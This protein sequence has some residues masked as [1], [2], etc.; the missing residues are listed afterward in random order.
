MKIQINK[1]ILNLLK[2]NNVYLRPYFNYGDAENKLVNVVS[3]VYAEEFS[4]IHENSLAWGGEGVSIGAFSYLVPGAIVPYTSIGRYCSIATGVRVMSPGHPIDRVTTSTWTYGGNINNIV[5][6]AYGV[7]I[8][9]NR[10]LKKNEKT[11]I[12]NDVWIGEFAVV[13]SGVTIGDGAVVAA[14]SVVT[15]DVP[16]YSIVAGNPARVVK[17]R[18]DQEIIENLQSSK[19][20][21]ASPAVLA[22]I[23]MLDPVGFLCE[24]S[25][26]YEEANY[27]R[28]DLKDIFINSD[29]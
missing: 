29:L 17:Y 11:I 25:S 15:K 1:Y 7:E 24:L 26:V 10:N 9:Q 28:V 13:K 3:S 14:Q 19:W 6:E 18:F 8:K 22:S 2:S 16:P 20:W 21:C 5:K 27:N 23:S 12:G 4:R